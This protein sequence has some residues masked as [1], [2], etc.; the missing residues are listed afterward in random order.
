MPTAIRETLMN[1]RGRD[2][3]LKA[4]IEETLDIAENQASRIYAS[5]WYLPDA[6]LESQQ[7]WYEFGGG[8]SG[9][10]CLI[11]TVGR[12]I[13]SLLGNSF[14]L[15]LIKYIEPTISF[16]EA[17][18]LNQ[19]RS[20]PFLL[21]LSKYQHEREVRLFKRYSWL[22][23][24]DFLRER[25]DLETLIKKI[26]ISPLLTGDQDRKLRRLFIDNGMPADLFLPRNAWFNAL[27]YVIAKQI[28]PSNKAAR[29]LE[30]R[31]SACSGLDNIWMLGPRLPGY[32]G[33]IGPA[34]PDLY[35]S[36][37]SRTVRK[38]DLGVLRP[39]NFS[40]APVCSVTAKTRISVINLGVSLRWLLSKKK[41]SDSRR[42][43]AIAGGFNTRCPS[44]SD[45]SK[46]SDKA[47]DSH[48][49]S[50]AVGPRT[51][52]HPFALWSGFVADHV[53][54]LEASASFEHAKSLS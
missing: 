41:R 2:P 36:R 17:F 47:T 4:F 21:K 5:C 29:N 49:A 51:I 33:C 14:G 12:L 22:K 1:Q 54:D 45:F 37:V 6:Y 19:Y 31:R 48:R 20:L 25:I 13:R 26:R 3:A 46:H 43:C 24:P 23:Q 40:I 8:K 11:T 27:Q 42:R 7:M 53:R 35:H 34:F 15:G 9:G 39:F 16:L 32:F 10:V 18:K 44:K 50:N 30:A 38:E 28:Y 52:G